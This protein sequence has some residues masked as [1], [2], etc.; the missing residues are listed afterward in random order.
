MPNVTRITVSIDEPLLEQFEKFLEENGYPTRSEGVKS[1]M[2]KALIENEWQTGHTEV[3]ATISMVYDHHKAGVM[4]KLT[5]I[6]HDFGELVVCTQ[7]VHL[8]HHNCME[9]LILKGLSERIRDF[10]NALKS[11]KGLKHCALSAATT[12]E[13]IH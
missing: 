6:Q 5:D 3:A 1:I 11:V 8:D 7:H 9:V 4:Q 12:G 13:D 2:R 10:H